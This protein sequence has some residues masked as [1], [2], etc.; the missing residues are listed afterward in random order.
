MPP[1]CSGHCRS[2]EAW[3]SIYNGGVNASPN[4]SAAVPI[5]EPHPKGDLVVIGGGCYGSYHARQLLRA[6]AKTGLDAGR[7][8]IVDR[9]PGCPARARFAA[10]PDVLFVQADWS[11]FYDA[12]FA[13]RAADT[14]DR[15][16]PT[17]ISPHL[18]FEWLRRRAAA[19]RAVTV[20]RFEELPPLPFHAQ[21]DT[22]TGL[23]S[24]ADWVCPVTCIEPDLCPAIKAPK[25]WEM[26]EAV[27]A[28]ARSRAA[29]GEPCDLVEV[30]RIRHFAFGVGAFPAARA[31]AAR[32]RL[33]RLLD[34]PPAGRPRRVLVGTVSSCH[35]V[36]NRMEIGA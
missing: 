23:L 30:F 6:R 17:P 5:P 21:S 27:Y 29:A 15:V 24:Y 31:V 19:R 10:E 34:A 4:R 25:A 16:V 1:P 7:I 36:M 28:F 11:D 3:P 32:E 2:A 14:R 12:Y 35:G 22:G 13:A 33:D 9:D 26:D 8:V 20:P 18:M